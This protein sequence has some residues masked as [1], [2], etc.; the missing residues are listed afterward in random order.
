MAEQ[1]WAGRYDGKA[2][3][4][5]DWTDKQ[6]QTRAVVEHLAAL[7]AVGETDPHTE[8]RVNCGVGL[9]LLFVGRIL[10]F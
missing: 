7:D 9:E 1:G 8:Q 6:R 4:E 10:A 5:F 2:P 3:D